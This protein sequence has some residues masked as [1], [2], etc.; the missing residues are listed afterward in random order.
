MAI[1]NKGILNSKTAYLRQVGN[2]WPTAQVVY[3]A[4]IPESSGN[5]Y[6]TNARVLAVTSSLTTANI[7]EVSSNLYF[8]NARVV[9]ALTAGQGIAIST[10]GTISTKG[11]DTGLGMFNSGINLANAM[12]LSNT[13]ANLVTFAPGDG[14]SFIVY[15]MHM[16]NFSANTAYVNARA[17]SGANTVVFANLFEIPGSSVAEFFLKPQLFKANDQIQMQSLD[18]TLQPANSLITALASYQGSTDS[19]FDRAFITL[20]DNNPANLFITTSKRSIIESLKIVNPNPVATPV[21]AYITDGSLNLFAYLAANVSIPAWSSLEL[22]ELPK[23]MPENYI[24][25]LQK[26]GTVANPI[27]AFSSTKYTTQ[28]T[29]L[30]SATTINEGGSV[31]FNITTLNIGNGT[32]LYYNTR[33]TSGNVL[34][35]D[36]VTANIGSIVVTNGVATITLQSNADA[37]SF[38]EGNEA[39]VIEL[40]KVSTTGTIVATSDPITIADTSNIVVFTSVAT[41]TIGSNILVANANLNVAI[42]S[43][44]LGQGELLYYTTTGNVVGTD[45][46]QGNTG[47]FAITNNAANLILTANN[48]QTIKS[49]TLN[50]YQGSNAGTVLSTVSN[51]TLYPT[52]QAYTVASGGSNTFIVTDN[53]VNY[54]VH[55]FETSGNL[56]VASAGGVFNTIQYIAVAGGGGGGGQPG[57]YPNG[58]GGAGAGAGGVIFG[59]VIAT[60]GNVVMSVGAGGGSATSGSNTSVFGN[61]YL[62]AKG[63][64]GG[65][66][67]TFQ[68]YNTGPN[69]GGP[70]GSGGGHGGRYYGTWDYGLGYPGQGQPG[71]TFLVG[72]DVVPGGNFC[73]G[74]GFSE[75]GA[76]TSIPGNSSSA[77]GR[78]GNGFSISWMTSSYGT[79]ATASGRWFAGG[80]SGGGTNSIRG[81]FG[82]GGGNFGGLTGNVNTG[83]GGAGNQGP[84]YGGYAGGSGIVIVRYRT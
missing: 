62:Q 41:A 33:S 80:G 32:T 26:S 74:G 5:L 77:S 22:C 55:V 52:N 56:T 6:F 53:G 1:I 51:V 9:S 37:T 72:G 49:F 13:Y 24:L 27:S 67:G 31:T 75:R 44:N 10:T 64:G 54:K 7:S 66:T 65:G 60:V 8:T 82:G 25:R 16:T 12:V 46:I 29:I 83:G 36:F 57:F 43:T 42:T 70:G 23:A 73:G 11:D 81:G 45:F 78:G 61:L 30:P 14:I 69:P 63:G 15:S 58:D 76:N 71:G 19:N 48:I 68:S 34:A 79:G 18:N 38:T 40:R 4:D 50:I 47:S 17:V 2:D 84:G 59:N 21:S 28:Y 39:F 3:T 35:G 20:T